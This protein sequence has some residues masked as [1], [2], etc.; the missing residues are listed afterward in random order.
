M[1]TP[2]YQ[3]HK[4]PGSLP[5]GAHTGLWFDKFCTQWRRDPQ[6]SGVASWSLKAF[7]QGDGKAKKEVNPKLDWIKTVTGQPIGSEELLAEHTARI[8]GLA[9]ALGG[10]SFVFQ[11]TSR[12]ATGLGREHPVEN[13]FTWHPVLGTPFLSGSSVKGLVRAWVEGGWAK[14]KTDP[15]VFHRIFGSDFRKGSYGHE[16][17]RHLSAQSGSIVFLDA[18]PTAS[19]Q[20][21]ADVMTP[22]YGK[23]YAGDGPPADWL[24]PNPIPF[25]TVAPGQSFQFALVPRTL[26]KAHCDD[27]ATVVTWLEVALTWLG[28]GAKTAVGYGRFAKADGAVTTTHQPDTSRPAA[29][30]AVPGPRYKPS[31]RVAARRVEDP[32]GKGRAWFQAEDGF[33]GVVTGGPPPQ[34]EVGQTIELDI[35]NVNQGGYN[36]R[37]P[38]TEP[39]PSRSKSPPKRR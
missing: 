27:C 20:L 23:Y 12:L 39:A 38:R 25:L 24:E 4:A 7:S 21:R 36:F 26:S 28:A 2:L 14:E 35:A 10:R 5:V 31:Q 17:R 15:V 13:G 18:I 8:V 9:R 29:I 30:V 11:T 33:G 19:V 16:P 37:L 22:H 32:R 34:V 3:N 1:T 6:K